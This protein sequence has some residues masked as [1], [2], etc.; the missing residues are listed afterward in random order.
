MFEG[1]KVSSD[2]LGRCAYLYI[3]Q[4]TLRQVL[5]NT[6]ST[7][8]QYAL[9]DRAI[10]LGWLP[11]SIV[12]IDSDLG[13]SG[14]TADR[15]GFQ[16]LVAEVTLGKA[17]IVMGIEVSRLAR[18][19]V[20]WTRLLE[21]CAF[22]DTLILD[23]DGIYDPKTF[24]DRLL[25]GLKGTISEAELHVLQ[26]RMQ[27][28]SLNKARRGELKTK[29]PIGFLYDDSDRII[30]DPDAQIQQ[31]IRTLFEV[32]R[33]TG[34]ACSTMRAFHEK[35][36]LFPHRVNL[37]PY[38]GELRWMPIAVSTVLRILHNPTYA[39]AYTFGKT[40]TR[41]GPDGR[42]RIRDVPRDQ[43]HVLILDAHPGYIAWEE[44]EDNLRRLR[45]NSHARGGDRRK[46]PPREGV[47][48]LQGLVIC[49]IC[50]KRMTVR[51][52][53]RKHET[54]PE[55]VCM[56][57]LIENGASHYQVVPGR[58]VE[59]AV[60]SLM[61]EAMSP[62]SVETALAVQSELEQRADETDRLRRRQV[63]RAQYEADLA[64]RRYMGVDPA[65]RL[66]ADQLE[67]EWNSKLRILAEA[68]DEYESFRNDVH[69]G[70]ISAGQRDQIA[71]LAADFMAIWDDSQVADR[72]RKRLVRLVIED[73]TLVKTDQIIM[74]VRFR[75]GA[76]KSLFL[77]P[78]AKPCEKWRTSDALL[79]RIETLSQRCTD[80]ESA[81]NLNRQ[82]FRSPLGKP[83]TG[84]IV[85]RIRSIYSIASYYNRLRAS[86]K[87]TLREIAAELGVCADT[88]RKRHK[89]GLIKGY[90]GNDRGECL[91][92]HPGDSA[93]VK[94][95]RRSGKTSAPAKP[96]QSG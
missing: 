22:T 45:Q 10:S 83:F 67:A 48:L 64:R 95:G 81:E 35:G 27:G 55:Y 9:R 13:Q 15:E 68:R 96:G 38:R 53:T 28:G 60:R 3:R 71:Q 74:N 18:S 87:L 37:G 20:E 66:V 76:L 8:R 75:G 89:R 73:V 78:S 33:W 84:E 59:K 58:N 86:G 17:G 31:A 90:R 12:V 57:D 6:E 29:L 77:A 26:A 69:A 11:E 85:A 72:E 19:S 56:R 7:K 24:N 32:F 39:G 36:M 63:E 40:K 42:S 80:S 46:G 41:K 34:S 50:G 21:I 2:H 14:T 91:F 61:I 88:I 52:H 79:K 1:S 16:K 51:Y 5:E 93:T 47:A 43:W 23:E 44:Y 30:L 25:L 94:R 92:D 62:L 70:T 54:V 49:G 65:N 82:G 4:S